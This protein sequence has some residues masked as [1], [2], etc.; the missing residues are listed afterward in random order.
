MAAR[1]FVLPQTPWRVDPHE[2]GATTARVQ[3]LK[4]TMS[5]ISWNDIV[6]NHNCLNHRETVSTWYGW[7]SA[8]IPMH[9]SMVPIDAFAQ[10]VL[11]G[12]YYS[13]MAIAGRCCSA[14]AADSDSCLTMVC[15]DLASM[16]AVRRRL[17]ESLQQEAGNSSSTLKRTVRL[18]RV[19]GGCI[20]AR[21][22]R[23]DRTLRS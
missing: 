18:R 12:T 14:V 21:G 8:Q 23:S 3:L 1:R 5:S 19:S 11:P 15:W 9:R 13:A 7:I 20:A 2:F 10:L 16:A 6:T 22:V 4:S 17:T